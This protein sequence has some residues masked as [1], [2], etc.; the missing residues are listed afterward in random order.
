[1]KKMRTALLETAAK[2]GLKVAMNST[3]RSIIGIHQPKEPKA[4]RK[5]VEAASK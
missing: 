2:T 5:Y 4:L 1:M 3:G